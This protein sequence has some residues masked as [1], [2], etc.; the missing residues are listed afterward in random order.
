MSM[1]CIQAGHICRLFSLFLKQWSW[2]VYTPSC[3]QWN[4]GECITLSRTPSISVQAVES[5]SVVATRFVALLLISWHKGG[6][7]RR[8]RAAAAAAATIW[9][10]NQNLQWGP[11]FYVQ[12]FSFLLYSFLVLC[13]LA[14]QCIKNIVIWLL[15]YLF[16][17]KD[18][19]R[20]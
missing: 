20:M 17:F 16:K 12:V 6:L 5:L 15:V 13:M 19:N 1:N 14:A 7:H 3:F 11:I 8:I 10:N 4:C 9:P 2:K 18:D